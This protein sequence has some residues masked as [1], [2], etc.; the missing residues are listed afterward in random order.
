[1]PAGTNRIAVRLADTG[2]L[3]A[4]GSILSAA[5]APGLFT[6]TQRGTG[7]AAA[8]N[9]D[10]TLNGSANPAP[11]G[12]IIT[13]YGTGQG[14]VSP[15]VLDGMPAPASPPATTVAV[16]T[17]DSRTCTTAQPSMCVAIGSSFGDVQFSG[18][19]PGCVGLWQINVKVPQGITAGGAVSV[20]VLINGVAT[21]PLG[22]GIVPAARRGVSRLH[23]G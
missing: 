19:A 20:R 4:G 22:D 1:V 21:L 8:V 5:T 15:T 17:S 13:L 14:Q 16:P 12:S 11:M 10:G 7:Q 3:V 6:T 18:L 9:Q 23:D 2:E